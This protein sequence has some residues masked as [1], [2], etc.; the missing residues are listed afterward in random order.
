MVVIRLARVG[1]KKYPVYRIVAAEKARAA[2]G[3]FLSILGT[4]NPHTKE[5]K[6]KKE[7]IQTYLQNGAQAS[8]RVLRLLKSE[9]VELPT[10]AKIHDRN[11]KP[12]TGKKGEGEKA[13]EKAAEVA[14]KASD[15]A[16]EKAASVDAPETAAT[17]EKV[18]K[19][20]KQATEAEAK[21][22]EEAK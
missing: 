13:P 14:E 11:K 18:A 5:L 16:E 22:S 17:E 3:K 1:R 10:W 19:D 12:K 20:Q 2:T 15:K 4:Y 21:A 6:L 9:G 8:D 7:D